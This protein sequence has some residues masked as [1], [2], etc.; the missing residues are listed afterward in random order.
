ML[1]EVLSNGLCSLQE[2]QPR[3][4]KSAFITYNA[5][6]G[7]KKTRA[8]NTVMRSTKRLVRI[9]G[10]EEWLPAKCEGIK[11]KVG[12]LLYFNTWGGGGWGDPCERDSELVLQDVRRK[13]VSVEGASHYG[14]SIDAKGEIDQQATASLRQAMR[15][16]RDPDAGIFNFGGTIAQI[17]SR[18]LQETHL[19]APEEPHFGQ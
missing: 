13:L 19:P 1:P 16:E 2:R 18:C 10:T 9:D 6:G 7:V 14:V 15:E 17:K 5:R 12:D 3:L 11:V 8:A 4:A